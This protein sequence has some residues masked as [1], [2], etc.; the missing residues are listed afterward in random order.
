M[1]HLAII[2]AMSFLAGGVV[3]HYRPPPI[4]QIIA[5]VKAPPE[6][7][8]HESEARRAQL[9]QRP[10]AADVV[11][12]GD[13]RIQQGVW[14]F[15]GITVANHGV[16]GDGFAEL[17]ARADVVVGMRPRLILIEAGINDHRRPIQEALSDFRTMLDTFKSSG[18]RIVI[19]SVI[20][21]V[22]AASP[23]V[24]RLNPLLEAEAKARGHKWLDTSAIAPSEMTHDGT[25]LSAEGYALWS[26]LIESSLRH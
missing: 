6:I 13:S 4:P 22:C 14:N 19:M 12:F 16:A 5:A 18:A 2:A 26:S 10:G 8:N 17:A 1:R 7:I 3:A 15:P 20:D 11:M 24:N 21:C 25:H 9:R 23:Y